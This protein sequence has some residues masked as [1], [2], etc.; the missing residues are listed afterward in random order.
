MILIQALMY[1]IKSQS[2]NLVYSL[3]LLVDFTPQARFNEP[4]KERCI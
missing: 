4:F 3:V 2:H 1:F